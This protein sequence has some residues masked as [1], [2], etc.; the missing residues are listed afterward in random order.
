[1]NLE[2]SRVN[3]EDS[4]TDPG[5]P[6][7]DRSQKAVKTL[8]FFSNSGEDALVVLRVLGPAK[9]LGMNVIRGIENGVLNPDLIREG[10]LVVIQRDFPRDLNAYEEV[11]SLAHRLAKPVVYDLDDLLLELP[12]LHPDRISHY[13]T[14]ALLPMLQAIIEADLIT[15]ATPALQSNLMHFNQNVEVFSNY[16]NDE[17][18]KILEPASG[19][20]NPETISIGYMGGHSHKPDI[21]MI[22]P[23]LVRIRKKF[24]Q[25]VIFK[26]WGIEPPKELAPYSH[27]DWCP[28]RSLDY[29][30]FV[31][32]FLTQS[33]N[34]MI[35]PL[36]D[37]AFNANKSAIKYLEY[38]A[39]GIPGVYSRV[40]PYETFIEDGTDG[41][42]AGSPDEWEK[43]L[44]S[45]ID[46][47]RLRKHVAMN[48]Q[49]K[50][51]DEWLLSRNAHKLEKIYVN[52]LKKYPCQERHASPFLATIRSIARQTFDNYQIRNFNI[53]ENRTMIAA[54]Q[55]QTTAMTASLQDQITSSNQHNA[56]QEEE[57]LSYALSNSWKFTRPLRKLAR[58]IRKGMR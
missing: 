55:D 2:E 35:A 21:E 26:F 43:A 58:L 48:A 20:A 52:A 13:F 3:L 5:Q 38:S 8:I 12:D 42:L 57:I 45:L 47:P 11:V 28:P 54:L 6:R 40:T 30:D 34:I 10:D 15:V 29:P 44:T 14:E 53:E 19:E 1:M 31:E 27:V 41:L 39:L 50:I 51:R 25:R 16:L 18:W 4:S 33:A 9:V 23:V 56:A 22:T 17:L 24:N 37:S 49:S 7:I 36:L 32:Y 46:D